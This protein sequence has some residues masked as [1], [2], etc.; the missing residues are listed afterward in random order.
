VSDPIAAGLRLLLDTSAVIAHLT[1]DEGVSVAASD[2]IDGAIATGRNDAVISAVT[3][4]E[5]LQRP[6]ASG[7][8]AVDRVLGLLDS[9]EALQ[10]RSVD[11]L[12]AAEA[13]RMRGLMRLELP[14]AIVLATG[15]LTSCQVLVTND[16]RMAAAARQAV[17]ELKVVLLSEVAA[18]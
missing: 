10:I 17:P 3:I 18:V 8:E 6:I 9:L 16:R 14:D 11:F 13:A 15:V 4:G 5:V 2:V 1:G 7:Q 12:V